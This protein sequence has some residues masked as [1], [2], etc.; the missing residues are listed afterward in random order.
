M[1]H[2]EM[3]FSG[4]GGQGLMLLGDAFAQAACMEGNEIVLTKSY[5]PESRGGACR[6]ELIIDEE[7]IDYPVLT[8]PA[9][10]VCLSQLSCDSYTKDIL[11]GGMLFVDEQL[12]TRLPENPLYQVY[13]APFTQMALETAGTKMAANMVVAGVVTRAAKLMNET[14]MRKAVLACS[15]PRFQENN[16][17][18]FEA[19][20]AYAAA[21]C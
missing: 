3:R 11:P 4:S 19:G 7:K 17:K 6:S 13:A 12:V 1:K 10:V 16:I 14:A 18:A 5:G 15:A 9:C 20:L 2:T 21:H 8:K